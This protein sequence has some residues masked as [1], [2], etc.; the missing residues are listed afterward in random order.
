M[1]QFLICAALVAGVVNPSWAAW[2]TVNPGDSQRLER[3]KDFIA[4]EQWERA[5]EQLKAAAADAK[6]RNK[7]EA[8][9]WLAHSQHQASDLAA[10]L[11]TIADLER[12]HATSPWVKPARSLRIEI[13]QK[14]RRND[15]LW[16]TAAPPGSPMAWWGPSAHAPRALPPATVT[17]PAPPRQPPPGPNPPAQPAPGPMPPRTSAPV[18]V[19]KTAPPPPDMLSTATPMAPPAPATVWMSRGPEPDTNLR[20]Q[21]LG[22]LMQTDA[23]R[24]IPMLRE[25]ALES[26]NPNEASR[27]IF[28]LAQSG[29]PE[30]RSTVVEVARTGSEL[31]QIAAV[32]ELGRFGGA[33]V[34]EELL[35][36]YRTGNPRVKFQVVNSLADR[37]ETTALL[38]I[39]QTES[40]RRLQ[41]TA[42]VRLGQ[43]GGREQLRR[44]Y[45]SARV[46]LKR[47][48]INGLFNARA[49]DELIHILEQERDAAIRADV[50]A[51][52]RILDTKK[53]Q[54]FLEK[55]SKK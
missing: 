24:V 17:S 38:R 44:F 10:A 13:A 29:N 39:A 15:V 1:K 27:A 6:E 3:A 32:K 2:P 19:S 22:S 53:A 26:P 20:I 37:F 33:K 36:V 34:S 42:I 30:A 8:L 54:E 31:V 51:K 46:E 45:T 21:A 50:L 7:D 5:I 52:L 11:Q 18:A 28:I 14:L 16:S 47:P 41:E 35:H 55:Q 25:I 40:D 4:D 43:A 9:F 23:K 48:I 49:V 12:A